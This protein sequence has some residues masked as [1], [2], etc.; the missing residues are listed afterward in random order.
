M[1]KIFLATTT[2][3]KP[4]KALEMFAENIGAELVVALDKKSKEFNLKNTLTLTTKYQEKKWPKLSKLIGWNCIQRRN[5][6]ILECLDR[7]A[8]VIGLI[9]DDNIPYRNWFSEFH[10][11]KKIKAN[12]YRTNL[13]IF[14][15]IGVTNYKNLW[16]RGFPIELVKRR[17]YSV[18]KKKIIKPDIQASFWNGDPDIDAVCRMIFKPEC[19]FKKKYF[20]FFSNKISPFNSQ[21]TLISRKVFKDYF[22]YPHIGRMDDIW[23][24]FYVTSKKYRVLYGEPTVYQKRNKHSLIKD[25][26]DEYIG[27]TNS[28]NLV[29]K[30]YINPDNIYNFLPKLSSLAFDEWKK[31]VQKIIL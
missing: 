27:Y 9:D 31:I 1:K 17:K 22:L 30:L 14:D 5:F 24:S 28:L 2:I 25:F 19:T 10:L 8:E 29:E 6:A 3:N 13:N 21:N 23:A 11:N 15:P 20:P 12:Y 7:G 26:K 16:H 18:K 4:T